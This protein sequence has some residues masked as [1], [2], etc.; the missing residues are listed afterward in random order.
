MWLV[1]IGVNLVIT[2][3]RREST[4]HAAGLNRWGNPTLPV[5]K[6]GSCWV[7]SLNPQH[8]I[9]VCCV[10][11]LQTGRNPQNMIGESLMGSNI[12][13]IPVIFS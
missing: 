1:A 8:A 4:Q 9:G 6:G 10:D 5:Y 11:S 7:S 2:C 12:L 3:P 13:G